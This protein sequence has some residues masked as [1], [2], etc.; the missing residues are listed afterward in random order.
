MQLCKGWLAGTGWSLPGGRER[1][2]TSLGCKGE[3]LEPPSLGGG[4]THGA[5]R[6]QS[7][8]WD[9]AQPRVAPELC[10][11]GAWS[12]PKQAGAAR[13]KPSVPQ[14]G[15]ETAAF[16]HGSRLSQRGRCQPGW[17]FRRSRNPPSRALQGG[18]VL[19]PTARER[20]ARLLW[21]AVGA[22]GGQGSH[23]RGAGH[24]LRFGEHGAFLPGS[25]FPLAASS[26]ERCLRGSRGRLAFSLRRSL[27][28][29]IC[30]SAP[31]PAQPVAEAGGPRPPSP[32]SSSLCPQGY[33][34]PS[35][36]D[37]FSTGKSSA[38]PTFPSARSKASAVQLGFLDRVLTPRSGVP[39]QV[40]AAPRCLG[41]SHTSTGAC[42]LSWG[43]WRLLRTRGTAAN[44]AQ[45][46]DRSRAEIPGAVSASLL[47]GLLPKAMNDIPK[48]QRR[49]DNLPALW[50]LSATAEIA[51][52]G[53]RSDPKNLN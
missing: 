47:K 35:P 41:Q 34:Q 8:W 19:L 17:V 2:G 10:N 29:A 7:C 18:Q 33:T 14:E 32:A 26:A 42:R 27:L 13:E 44:Q 3:M 16:V 30:P 15:A 20:A 31:A 6:M 49:E 1:W 46:R 48:I 28:S 25:A 11:T 43:P 9:P 24:S 37:V 52:W 51:A 4:C 39:G 21:G 23:A 45:H 40:F 5:Q 36:E 50:G 38:T 53:Q 12:H 22:E